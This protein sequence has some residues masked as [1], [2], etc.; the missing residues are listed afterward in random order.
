[1]SE[2]P[3]TKGQTEYETKRAAKAGKT[4]EVWLRDKARAEAAAA[5]A[6]KPKPVKKPGLLSRLID[7]GHQPLKGR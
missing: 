7:K 3:L 5:E 2:K 1:M 6:D 4:L